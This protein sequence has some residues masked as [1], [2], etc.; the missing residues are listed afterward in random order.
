VKVPTTLVG[1]YNSTSSI[2]AKA[3]I[4]GSSVI[5]GGW[6]CYS[7]ISRLR[8][9]LAKSPWSHRKGSF[10]SLKLGGRQILG[11]K[12]KGLNPRHENKNVEKV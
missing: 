7:F 9:T 6:C 1:C 11:F 4:S 3:L 5:F 2:S 8:E 12:S 10:L